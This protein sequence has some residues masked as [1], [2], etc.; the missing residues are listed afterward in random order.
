MGCASDCMARANIRDSRILRPT[1]LLIFRY[2]IG[3]YP[4][5][6]DRPPNSGNTNF[7]RFV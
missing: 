1:C 5:C 2:C 3:W 7:E 4:T 6:D